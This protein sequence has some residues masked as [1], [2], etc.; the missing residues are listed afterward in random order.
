MFSEAEQY[1]SNSEEIVEV[2]KEI[3]ETLTNWGGGI[4]N[5]KLPY[6]F[7]PSWSYIYTV[8]FLE[9]KYI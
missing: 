3:K 8:A 7:M 2:K 1:G 9:T 6:P 4:Y 5:P